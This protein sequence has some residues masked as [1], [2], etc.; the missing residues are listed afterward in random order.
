MHRSPANF[1]GRCHVCNVVSVD[2]VLFRV[3][4]LKQKEGNK[5]TSE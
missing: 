3:I 1:H 5:I 2:E 4:V